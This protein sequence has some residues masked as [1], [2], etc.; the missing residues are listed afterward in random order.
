MRR[1]M[2]PVMKGNKEVNEGM[3]LWLVDDANCYRVYQRGKA[4]DLDFGIDL[5]FAHDT[6]YVPVEP[7]KG[8]PVLKDGAVVHESFYMPAKDLLDIVLLSN[9]NLMAIDAASTYPQKVMLGNECDFTD[10][11]VGGVCKGGAWYVMGE[12]GALNLSGKCPSCNGSGLSVSLGPNKVL[13]IRAPSMRDGA[14]PVKVQDAMTYVEPSPSTTESL[15]KRIEENRTAARKQLHLYSEQPMTGGDA[16]SATQVGVGVKAQNAFI[17]PI[18]SQIFGTMDFVLQTITIQRYGDAEGYYDL[19]PATQ[20]DLRTEA[21]YIAM[22]GEAQA[23]GL[24]PSAIEEILRGFFAARYGSDPYMA[25]AFEVIAN[26]DTLLTTNWQ[27]LQAMQAKSQVEQWEVIL[28][29]RALSLYDELMRDPSFRALEPFEKAERLRAKAQEVAGG[30]TATAQPAQT[31]AQRA[32]SHVQQTEGEGDQAMIDGVID[33]LRGIA[34]MDNRQRSAEERLAN[35]A[36]E[37]V[38][39]DRADF[40]ARVMA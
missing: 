38:T 7:L 32:L 28:H 10:A 29:Q 15:T 12:E 24:P 23:K 8:R 21:D 35:F 30:Q 22:L 37:G 17:A 4:H 26:A 25:E 11:R 13:L 1:E 2:S 27:Q 33:I 6:G 3:V 31:P 19:I 9:A 39:V 18:A 16:P 40:L 5:Y 34:D 36:A 14:T 20:Y